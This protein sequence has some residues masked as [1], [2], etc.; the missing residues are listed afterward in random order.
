LFLT[1]N[2][3][4]HSSAGLAVAPWK[5]LSTAD[6][7][8]GTRSRA[9]SL[10]RGAAP[11]PEPSEVAAQ[12]PKVPTTVRPSTAAQTAA[13]GGPGGV[14]GA[15]AVPGSG[16]VSSGGVAA[17]G[18]LPPTSSP[19]ST[20]AQIVPAAG[21]G[22]A[23]PVLPVS[24]TDVPTEDDAWEELDAT[25]D[26]VAREFKAALLRFQATSDPFRVRIATG[27]PSRAF[28]LRDFTRCVFQALREA[29]RWKAAHNLRLRG[30]NERLFQE[31]ADLRRELEV[32]RKAAGEATRLRGERDEARKDAS[33]ERRKREDAEGVSAQLAEEVQQL[34]TKAQLDEAALDRL[35]KLLDELRVACGGE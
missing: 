1:L 35:R 2:L 33:D 22:F 25:L 12:A 5:R 11:A 3:C 19:S 34:R 20:G 24:A 13:G 9:G 4:V 29:A 31:A 16:V 32:Q 10:E 23:P 26:E 17:Q 30:E 18:A 8:Q 6:K 14:Q 21:S 28:A 15:S 27:H 7:C